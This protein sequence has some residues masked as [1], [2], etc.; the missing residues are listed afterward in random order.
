MRKGAWAIGSAA[1]LWS[2]SA[3]AQIPVTDAANLANTTRQV[4]QGAQQVQQLLNQLSV[5]Q[6]Q[7]AQLIQT[8]QAIAHLPD[9]ALQQLASQLNVQQF[10][11]PLPTSSSMVGDLMTGSGLSQLGV[12]GQQFLNQNRLYVPSGNDFAARQLTGTANSIAGVQGMLNN[13]YQSASGRITVLQGLE[14][15]LASAKDDKAVADLS[16]RIQAES[17]YLQAQHVQ[18]QV[19]QTWQASQ[20]RNE[21]QQT[22]EQRRCYIDQVLAKVDANSGST[23]SSVT[24]DC[25]GVTAAAS[26][27][28]ISSGSTNSTSSTAANDGSALG[29]MMGQDWGN[30]AAS[31]ATAMG[32]NPTALAATCVLESGCRN[33]GGQ[34]SVSGAFQ[35]TNATYTTDI[36]KALQANPSLAD[37]AVS[38]LA[39]KMDPATQSI[40]ASQEL[41]TAAQSLQASGIDNPTVLDTRGYYNF[42]AKYGAVLAQASDDQ[43]MATLMPT[44]SA[45]QLAT[46]GITS[47]MTVGQWRQSITSK[48]GTAASQRVLGS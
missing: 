34:G 41:K 40:A 18:A 11:T 16:A 7:Y 12:V 38:G 31:N 2:L 29:K 6:Q 23:T 8:Y 47:T 46:N 28:A 15:Q 22:R 30:A 24:S 43:N 27:G 45:K 14:G 36:N 48:I 13:L 17:T 32:V 26:T 35:M 4:I 39:G 21:T 5:M 19:L 37:S 42:G 25:S 20:V 10:R 33:V 3:K 1:L 44:Y 9:T